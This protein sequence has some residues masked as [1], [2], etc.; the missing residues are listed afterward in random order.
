MMALNLHHNGVVA[1]AILSA[2]V[3]G[4]VAL[5][6]EVTSAA[7]VATIAAGCIDTAR[8]FFREDTVLPIDL[9]Y[10]YKILYVGW[11][12][13]DTQEAKAFLSVLAAADFA[14]AMDETW[15]YPASTMSRTCG[16][17]SV[18]LGLEVINSM[19]TSVSVPLLGAIGG[20]LHPWVTTSISGELLRHVNKARGVP[21][22]SGRSR[23]D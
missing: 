22:T 7:Y 12:M 1:I 3:A 4:Q 11:L 18:T 23:R 13:E 17:L 9:Y 2:F 19:G 20:L 10:T 21:L 8:R 5:H 16:M 15:S 6:D 14:A